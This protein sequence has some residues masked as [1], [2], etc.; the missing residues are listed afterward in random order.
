MRRMISI[1]LAL[2]MLL[3]I[4]PIQALAAENPDEEKLRQELSKMVDAEE[5]PDGLI[6]FLTPRM[7]CAE[8]QEFVE[9]VVARYGSTNSEATV[10]FKAIDISAKYG[11]DYYITFPKALWSDKLEMDEDAQPIMDI[12]AENADKSVVTLGDK[13]AD[14]TPENE[15]IPNAKETPVIEKS[16]KVEEERL[17]YSGGTV[18]LPNASDGPVDALASARSAL[19]G[20]ESDTTSWQDGD[21]SQ[22]KVAEALLAENISYYDEMPGANYTLHFAPGENMKVLRFYTIDDDIA[23][24]DEQV[25]FALLNAEGTALDANPTGF[26]NITD[27]DEAEPSVYAF[28][29]KSVHAENGDTYVTATLV[30]SEGLEKYDIVTLGTSA[31]TAVPGV[32]Y[33]ALEQEITFV[34]GQ[35]RQ[36]VQI[37]VLSRSREETVTFNLQTRYDD[38]NAA[39]TVVLPAGSEEVIDSSNTALNDSSKNSTSLEVLLRRPA[40]EDKDGNVKGY[41]WDTETHHTATSTTY[42]IGTMSFVG[43]AADVN[44][45]ILH[46]D[47]SGGVCFQAAYD[48]DVTQDVVDKTYL[49]GYKIERTPGQTDGI[50][51]YYLQSIAFDPTAFFNDQMRDSTTGKTI[52]HKSCLNTNA[53]SGADYTVVIQ[54]VFKAKD[55]AVQMNWEDEKL[56]GYQDT[57]T[58]GKTMTIGM[59]DTI[60][61]HLVSKPGSNDLPSVYRAFA[62]DSWRGDPTQQER[63]AVSYTVVNRGYDQTEVTG[64][65]TLTGKGGKTKTERI[66]FQLPP[67]GPRSSGSVTIPAGDLSL[68]DL[69]SATMSFDNPPPITVQLFVSRMLMG[70]K[71]QEVKSPSCDINSEDDVC[72]GEAEYTDVLKPLTGIQYNAADPGKLSFSPTAPYTVINALTGTTEVDVRYDPAAYGV[73]KENGTVYY[74]QKDGEVTQVD[75]DKGLTVGGTQL[76]QPLT[77]F[78]LYADEGKVDGSESAIRDDY[79]VVWKDWTGDVNRDGVISEEENALLGKY[80]SQIN[81]IA[82]MGNSYQFTPILPNSQLYYSFIKRDPLPAGADYSIRGRIYL[83]SYKVIDYNQRDTKAKDTPVEGASITVDGKTIRTNADGSFSFSSKYFRN[84][85]N[86]LATIEY[87]G[88]TYNTVLQMN[89]FTDIYLDEHRYFTPHDFKGYLKNGSNYDSMDLSNPLYPNNGD[90]DQLWT[91]SLAENMPNVSAKEVYLNIYSKEG[92]LLTRQ[93]AEYNSDTYLWEVEFNPSNYNDNKEEKANVIPAGATMTI[94]VTDNNGISYPEFD[95]GVSFVKKIDTITFLNSFKTPVS[96]VIDYIG[97][98]DAEFDLGLVAKADELLDNSTS[99]SDDSVLISFGISKDFSGSFSK[100]DDKKDDDKKEP[101][102]GALTAGDGNATDISAMDYLKNLANVI[103]KPGTSDLDKAKAAAEAAKAVSGDQTKSGHLIEGYKLDI[104]VGFYL[105]MKQD[106]EK[107]EFYFDNLVA[108]ATLLA[109][110]GHKF[111]MSTPIGITLNAYLGAGGSATALMVVEPYNYAKVY[112][113]GD[114]QIDLSKAGTTDINRELNIYGKFFVQPSVTIGAG[115]SLSSLAGVMV[116]GSATFDMAFS[117]TGS[118]QGSVEVTCDLALDLLGGLMHKSWTLAD[119]T[120]DL[121]NYSNSVALSG[122]DDYRYDSIKAG[123]TMERDYLNNRSGWSGAPNLTGSTGWSDEHTLENGVY[124]YA[125][126]LILD[127]GENA[128]GKTDQLMVFMD[129]DASQKHIQNS[130]RL[131]Y[132]VYTNGNWSEP[133]PVDNDGNNDDSPSIYDVGDSI[134]AL[135]SSAAETVTADTPPIDAMNHRNIKARFFNKTTRTWGEISDVTMTTDQDNTGDNAGAVIYCEDDNGKRHLMVTYEKN[136]YVSSSNGEDDALVGDLL[137]PMS[138]LAY[139]FYDFDSETW[140]DTYD[141]ETMRTLTKALSSEAAA[142]SFEE[143]WYGQNFVNLSDYVSAANTS[144]SI[145]DDPSIV[146]NEGIG[147]VDS[148]GHAIGLGAYLADADGINSTVD[149]RDIFLQFYDFTDNIHYTPIRLTE[150]SVEQSYISTAATMDGAELFFLSN[151]E[152]QELNVSELWENL[153]DIDKDTKGLNGAPNIVTA[154]TSLDENLPITEFVVDTAGDNDYIFWT[155]RSI[156]YVDGVEPGSTEAGQPENQ[157]AE[158]HIY[159]AVRAANDTDGTLLTARERNWGGAVQLTDEK[160]ANFSDIDIAPLGQNAIRMVYLKGQSALESVGNQTVAAEDIQNRSLHTA[161]FDLAYSRYNVA[162][163]PIDTLPSGGGTV[164]VTANVK[165]DGFLSDNTNLYVRLSASVNGGSVQ[166]VDTVKVANLDSGRSRDIAFDWEVPDGLENVEFTAQAVYIDS[167]NEHVCDTDTYSYTRSANIKITVLDSATIDRNLAQ[168]TVRLNNDGDAAVVDQTVAY[169]G[170]L[171]NGESQPYT[172]LPGGETTLTFWV[173]IPEDGF[174]S[175]T[176]EDGSAA[177]TAEITLLTDEAYAIATV[178]RTATA[179]E[180]ALMNAIESVVLT[181]VDGNKLGDSITVEQNEIVTLGIAA[182]MADGY[183][184]SELTTVLVSEDGKIIC[185]GNTFMATDTAGGTLTAYI[186]PNGNAVLLSADGTSQT[187]DMLGTLANAAIKTLT[188]NVNVKSSPVTADSVTLSSTELSLTEGDTSTL[189]AAVS[190]QDAGE[191]SWSVS[192]DGIVEISADG[193]NVTI[194]AK[195]A[196]TATIAATINGQTA[197]CDVT[198]TTAGGGSETEPTTPTSEPAPAPTPTPK[199]DDP[200]PTQEP[201]ELSKPTVPNN[202]TSPDDTPKNPS[203]SQST[204]STPQTDDNSNVTLWTILLLLSLAGIAI[205]LFSQKKLKLFKTSNRHTK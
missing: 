25:L 98:V 205:T 17:T 140:V 21:E 34:P 79:A 107:G 204:N 95:V 101:A 202:P 61:Y 176:L 177:D 110:A 62:I 10:E 24:S 135:W 74:S 153:V 46:P 128:D 188:L 8:G 36:T 53:G 96:G 179:E 3:S 6:S 52:L 27:N 187:L 130:T 109:D 70:N 80:A 99:S 23:E 127:I 115:V 122:I 182:E 146:E 172:L 32:D 2:L 175:Q 151:G 123:E 160:G 142:A 147:F 173:Y 111:S 33:P 108:C 158:R 20:V 91:F 150:D 103:S 118:G 64:T 76:G 42:R 39:V 38:D 139:R 11:E 136:A 55:A 168:L 71:V 194:T 68:D 16:P 19:L 120:W 183:D 88:V 87:Q 106:K 86:Y 49:W 186:I 113:D 181:D 13:S 29:E 63:Y 138:T 191:V 66:S 89:A 131:Y 90:A 40:E 163:E 1:L 104:G 12:T 31:L 170:D 203:S 121:F 155:E 171:V 126:P 75:P 97:N 154:V 144:N 59:L 58:N 185:N 7:E 56:E 65:I 15:E 178:Q 57:F 77:F 54:P 5:Y 132:T 102:N 94:S 124:P 78:G 198:V 50:Q 157:L 45:K 196:G 112:F 119:K 100:D 197:T 26:M 67:H 41:T 105:S 169:T 47:G 137:E 152:V 73:G 69:A 92:E 14:E 84:N 60:N 18:K 117:T 159:A 37:P 200:T 190:P 22:E 4:L 125:Y 164:K 167:S 28:E 85:E 116:T 43:E 134:L 72:Y 133:L 161:D 143:N 9:F 195:K 193:N 162:L 35:T 145:G 180:T 82:V 192:P 174:D 51:W 149:D 166:V 114:G 165:N 189:T 44:S 141:A 148:N 93:T 199:P 81:R 129:T 201:T 30:R 156:G 48:S 83:H 184:S